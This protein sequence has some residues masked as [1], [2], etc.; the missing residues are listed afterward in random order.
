MKKYIFLLLCICIAS[1]IAFAQACNDLDVITT[2]DTTFTDG[3][4]TAN[5]DSDVSCSWHLVSNSEEQ[6]LLTFTE[7]S[8]EACCDIVRVYDGEDDAATLL[9]THGG[10]ELPPAVASSGNELYIT[11]DTDGSVQSTGWTAQGD[12]SDDELID[13]VL[14]DGTFGLLTSMSTVTYDIEFINR[15]NAHVDTAIVWISG[16]T[17]Y[18][19]TPDD[20]VILSIVVTDIAPN[21]VISL[22][23][24]V[25]ARDSLPPGEYRV[26]VLLDPED[27]VEEYNEGNNSYTTFRRIYIPYCDELE[28]ITGCSGEISDGSGDASPIE[29]G[30]CSWRIVGE[31][32]TFVQLDINLLDLGWSD[33]LRIHSGQGP[34]DPLLYQ[35]SQQSEATTVISDTNYMFI[36]YTTSFSTQDGWSADYSCA[37]DR[38]VNLL[39]SERTIINVSATEISGVV[40]VINLGNMGSEESSV[41]IFLSQDGTVDEDD[42]LLDSL[43]VPPLDVRER[44]D[45]SISYDAQDHVGGGYYNILFRIDYRDQIDELNEDDN[46][47]SFSEE[48][49]VPYCADTL[50]LLTGCE[51]NVNDGSEIVDNVI[52]GADC[53]WLITGS[54]SMTLV[55]E[56]QY[57]LIGSSDRL[58]IYDGSDASATL[59]DQYSGFGVEVPDVIA[60]STHQAYITYEGV[61]NFAQGWSFDYSC[62]QDTLY[63][64]MI[65]DN[66][67]DVLRDDDSFTTRFTARNMSNK[68][69]GPTSAYLYLSQN[70][71]L[72]ETDLVIDSITIPSLEPYE[73]H[74]VDLFR[75]F[76][77][78]DVFGTYFLGVWLDG[79]NVVSEFDEVNNLQLDF[80]SLRFPFCRDLTEIS[81]ECSG[82]I[83]DGSGPS[84]YQ[85]DVDCRWLMTADT[86]F[87]YRLEFSQF[88]VETD[89]DWLT[90]YDGSTT[91][92]PVLGEFTGFDIP[93]AVVSTQENVL[94]RFTTDGFTER[95]G[96]SLD[97]SCIELM[98]NL[99]FDQ[100]RS[101]L[102]VIGE[103]I[104]F[105]GVVTNTG[106][107]AT[108]AFKTGIIASEDDVATIGDIVLGRYDVPELDP[109][110][111]YVL[112]INLRVNSE[113]VP[114]SEFYFIAA[115]D[116]DRA[117]SE[118][119]E[120]DN[121]YTSFRAITVSSD[122]LLGPILDFYYIDA[123]ESVFLQS[124]EDLRCYSLRAVSM[125]GQ[126]ITLLEDFE[127]I[128]GTLRTVRVD[129]LATGIYVL[130]LS[131][132]QGVRTRKVF[133]R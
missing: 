60:L 103:D 44:H 39:P 48:V 126:E 80:S 24:T 37:T 91:S 82:N 114:W 66:S 93:E 43:V 12:C 20:P 130:H 64:I 54:D 16:T 61:T 89:D 8:T 106:K 9:L 102:Q 105:E 116:I 115:L 78:F 25:D 56:T 122:D 71:T 6:L 2:C 45:Q 31:V 27:M 131:A 33:E 111:E 52:R 108:P 1:H 14:T 129:A 132:D 119:N 81:G 58:S 36:S 41:H 23:G 59:I 63:D 94:I 109:G 107:A 74:D 68:R 125:N 28:I 90:I 97:F 26:G 55:L 113:N 87:V 127:L 84:S 101:V 83:R 65:E 77:D 99:T 34:D 17:D 79:N 70:T 38:I 120:E 53:Q 7:F 15:G 76:E 124:S 5:Y 21:E 22:E 30:Y 40:S 123:Q 69:I 13:L 19:V 112:S 100:S 128:A 72:S 4:G 47:Q 121:F 29:E 88:D 86:G 46:G 62:T 32:G 96:W 104:L 75:A 10:S 92:S 85:A 49:G 3:S 98:P 73:S 57:W 118:E 117:V 42:Y 11:F 67:L 133:V 35:L 110:E 51:G 95:S 50:A 18:E